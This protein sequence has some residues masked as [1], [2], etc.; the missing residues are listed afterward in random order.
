LQFRGICLGV[1]DIQV[2]LSLVN[3]GLIRAGIN[4]YQE[5]ALLDW[6]VVVDK[7]F[8]SVPRNLWGNGSDVRIYLRV[9]R[10][11]AAGKH[12]PRHRD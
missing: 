12:V 1:G 5:V 3:L 9:I 2:G 10:R 8:Y 6:R 11:H 4:L 7:K